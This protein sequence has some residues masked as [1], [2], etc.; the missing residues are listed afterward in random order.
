M[1]I[2]YWILGIAAI[3]GC[4]YLLFVGGSAPTLSPPMQEGVI[5]PLDHVKGNATS[6]VLIV[7]YSDFQCPACKAYYPVIRQIVAEYGDRI[8]LVY[9]HFPLVTIHMNAE[10]AARASEA[11]N[12][13]GKFWEM[14]D[15]LF[16]K[17]NEWSEAV[18]PIKY[19]ESYASLI[20][21]SVDQFKTDF[22]SK[23]VRDLVKAERLHG[24]QIGLQG[25]PTFFVNGVQIQNPQSFEEFKDIINSAL[26]NKN[27]N[28]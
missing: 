28:Q 14:H 25:T 16:E 22:A 9:R 27:Q 21:I 7:E 1:K 20:G 24:L 26:Q 5:H 10:F 2:I 8:A 15:M 4:G 18:D 19:F 12:K 11:A 17:Q 13:Q 23:D 6:T 3:V